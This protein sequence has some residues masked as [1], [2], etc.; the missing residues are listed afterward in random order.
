MPRQVTAGGSVFSYLGNNAYQTWPSS[1]TSVGS[2]SGILGFT[3]N[4][5]TSKS[6]DDNTVKMG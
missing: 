5:A 3:N 2:H 6:Y 4:T 1:T